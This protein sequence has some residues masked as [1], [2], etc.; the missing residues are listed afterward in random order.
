MKVRIN[1]YISM[2]GYT[3]R[4]KADELI[5]RGMVFVNDTL[6]KE[7]GLSV[8]TEKDK[9]RV[10]DEELIF[11]N[12]RYILLNKPKLYLT[13]LENNEDDKNTIVDLIDDI[14]ERVYPVG[15]LDYDVEGLL[16]LTN[17]GEIAHKIHHPSF[18]VPKEYV[19]VL[20]TK[21]GFKDLERLSKGAELQ[22]GFVKPDSIKIPGDNKSSN[23]VVI[24]F[25]E[26]RNH[27]VKKYFSH[28]GYKIIKLKRV[29]IGPLSLGDLKKG[30]WRD[31]SKKE[32]A[33]LFDYFT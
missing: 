19:C 31:L 2:C 8:D 22:D 1:R 6:V 20:N 28:F 18:T 23:L 24:K 16:F 30:E 14:A 21:V 32:T 7:P 27:L 4:R 12:K 11:E 26:G 10:E 33:A 3:S 25:H 17:D 15:R 9:V 29:S 5:D 13:T